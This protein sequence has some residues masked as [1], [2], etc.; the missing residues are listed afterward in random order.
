MSDFALN[1]KH[2]EIIQ[3]IFLGIVEGFTEF[4]PISSTGHLIVAQNVIG[5]K[6]AAELFTVVIQ[7]GAIAAVTWF[8]RKDIIRRLKA[9][10]QHDKGSYRFWVNIIIATIPALIV[11]VVFSDLIERIGRPGVVGVMLI[12]GGLFLWHVETK[13]KTTLQVPRQPHH[14]N[15]PK[16]DSITSSQALKVGLAQ[17]VAL[18]PGVSRSG[19]S[20]V[21]GMLSGMDRLTATAFSFYLS[22]PIMIAATGY[23]LLKDWDHISSLPGG[24]TALIAGTIAAFITALLAVKWLL[25]YVSGH[26]L[27]GFAVYRMIVGALILLLV[28]VRIIR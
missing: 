7:I 22:I 27:K 26:D 6:D 20:I 4:L 17:T 8:Y 10:M 15:E 12:L 18:V 13:F 24:L 11:G 28:I 23:K 16:F 9:I 1:L 21:G 2:M 14:R 5:Y 25:K 3:A 19:A